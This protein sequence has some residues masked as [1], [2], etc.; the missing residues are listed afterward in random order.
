M[1]ENETNGTNGKWKK[2]LKWF[3]PETVR[4][5]ILYLR[6]EERLSNDYNIED[7]EILAIIVTNAA[8]NVDQRKDALEKLAMRYWGSPKP[9]YIVPTTDSKLTQAFVKKDISQQ[10]LNLRIK[11]TFQEKGLEEIAKNAAF[12]EWLNKNEEAGYSVIRDAGPSSGPF[13][14]AMI[15]GLPMDKALKHP[16]EGT[17][18][19][20]LRAL[21]D[22][23]GEYYFK[24]EHVIKIPQPGQAQYSVNLW[25][26]ALTRLANKLP[27][28]VKSSCVEDIRQA[29]GSLIS[30]LQE[31]TPVTYSAPDAKL[32]N[33]IYIAET[34]QPD[35]K[36]I[37]MSDRGFNENVFK[38]VLLDAE[39]KAR[40]E[41]F[42][43]Y[44]ALP[45]MDLG[46]LYESMMRDPELKDINHLLDDTVNTFLD[47]GIWQ[48]PGS[49][50]TY[51]LNYWDPLLAKAAF[52]FGRLYYILSLEVKSASIRD[53]REDMIKEIKKASPNP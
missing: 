4:N 19:E 28:E 20:Y 24:D 5:S 46:C 1:P 50:N 6:P 49:Q 26:E 29:A 52:K 17:R 42:D 44:L 2:F 21:L 16:D 36:Y 27:V 45:F 25:K 31:N 15:E 51:E 12:F 48:A 14:I 10:K 37:A 13:Y 8:L 34:G 3:S 9:D 47:T 32:S 40:I 22:F 7:A 38:Q 23:V 43:R 41:T 35:G 53:A 11:Y 30:I 18:Q 39:D 33:F